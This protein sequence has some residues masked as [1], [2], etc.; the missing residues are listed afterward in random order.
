V[1]SH[2]SKKKLDFETT[3]EQPTEMKTNILNLPYLDSEQ[4][5]EDESPAIKSPEHSIEFSQ[6]C[7][8]FT[9]TEEGETSKSTK[10]KKT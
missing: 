4:E 10:S 1:K 2:K 6:N 8:T 3:T 7:E 5:Q 9:H